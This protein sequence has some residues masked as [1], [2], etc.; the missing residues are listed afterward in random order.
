MNRKESRQLLIELVKAS[1]QEL[2]DRAEDLVGNGD[3]ISSFDIWITFPTDD[4][5]KIEVSRE[6]LV[7]NSLKVLTGIEEE[8]DGSAL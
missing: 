7:K 3:Y 4:V 8:D 1:G 2:I 5:P 6:H